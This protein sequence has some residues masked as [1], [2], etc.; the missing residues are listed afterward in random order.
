M[1]PHTKSIASKGKCRNE[2][3]RQ[4]IA[5]TEGR[6]GKEEEK[7]RERKKRG[8]EEECDALWLESVGGL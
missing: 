4:K 2:V 8:A 3:R 6:E 5:V 1:W 7:R